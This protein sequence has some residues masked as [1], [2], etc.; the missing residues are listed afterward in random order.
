MTA[1][2]DEL[3]IAAEGAA[4]HGSTE[5]RVTAVNHLINVLDDRVTRMK[6]INYLLIIIFEYFL[7]DVHK[8]IMKQ[9]RQKENSLYPSR[10]RGRGAEVSKTLFYWS[11]ER[12]E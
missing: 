11:M 12:S 10:L 5:G 2:R 6:D 4:V 3:E 1:E 7:K 8:I 9:L